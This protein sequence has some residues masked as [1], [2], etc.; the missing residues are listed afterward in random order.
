[1]WQQDLH[2]HTTWSCNDPAVAPEQRIELVAAVQHARIVGI[3][4]H[5]EHLPPDDLESYA[6]S[7]RGAGLYVGTEVD[8][9]P[10]VAAAAAFPFDYYVY[11]CRDEEAEYAGL[12]Q[13][14]ATER[15]VI[16]AHPHMLDT[17]LGRL[18]QGCLVELN[19]RYVARCDW[20]GFYGPFVGRFRFVLSSDAH[21]PGW[22]GQSV[23]AYVA[24]E[25]GIRE[26]RVFAEP[27]ER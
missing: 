7:V 1:M 20:R 27:A 9:A 22:L 2:I 17:D 10:S 21:Q 24:R 25:L 14:M 11:H 8:G 26:H 12:E 5:F 15:P 6:R 3:S 13:L 16:V 4:D 23:A 19:N 18:P